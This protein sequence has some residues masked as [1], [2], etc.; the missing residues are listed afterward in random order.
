G[1]EAPAPAAARRRRVIDLEVLPRPQ[2]E[3]RPAARAGRR[4]EPHGRRHG[5][6]AVVAEG[7]ERLLARA[8]LVLA[9]RRQPHEVVE[10]PHVVAADAGGLE[11]LLEERARG[12]PHAIELAREP[13]RLE[14]AH[15]LERHRLDGGVVIALVAA[16]SG[17]HPF[18]LRSTIASAKR[19]A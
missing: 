2:D 4:A 3:R 18:V 12:V 9:G 10:T 8:E 7:R 14:R 15:A 6:A 16:R 1:P 5:R 11:L 17:P 19:G 13:C